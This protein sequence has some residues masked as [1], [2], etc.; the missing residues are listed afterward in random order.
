M[1]HRDGRVVVV[2]ASVIPLVIDGEVTAVY[3]GCRDVTAAD[4]A[5]RLFTLLKGGAGASI[6]D[7][8]LMGM[9]GAAIDCIVPIGTDGSAR[10]LGAVWFAEDA[11]RRG[12]SI[13]DL[14]RAA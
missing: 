9:M 11:A 6:G 7:D 5:R 8:V 4:A 3:A 10:H 14:L 12:E 13:A 1:P 2:R